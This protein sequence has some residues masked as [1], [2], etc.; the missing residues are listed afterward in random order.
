[1]RAKPRRRGLRKGKGKIKSRAVFI[2]LVCSFADLQDQVSW[3]SQKTSIS[4]KT[5][6]SDLEVVERDISSEHAQLVSRLVSDL[7]AATSEQN[8][9]TRSDFEQRINRLEKVIILQV[10]DC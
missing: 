7:K 5:L 6:A 8:M 3:L 2:S 9:Q 10:R 1:M 4:L